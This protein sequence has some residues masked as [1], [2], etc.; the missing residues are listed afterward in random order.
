[1]SVV[2]QTLRRAAR[3]VASHTVNLVYATQLPPSV[4]TPIR[5]RVDLDFRANDPEALRL[6]LSGD[7]DY[8]I[9][10]HV[11][12]R[13]RIALDEGE[14]CMSAWSGPALAWYAMAQ[15][16]HHRVGARR[17]P[18]GQACSYVYL[19]YTHPQWRG[20]GVCSAGLYHLLAWLT[21]RGCRKALLDVTPE[22][23]ASRRVI[24][25]N[26]MRLVSRFDVYRVLGMRWATYPPSLPRELGS[27]GADATRRRA[28]AT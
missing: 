5:A 26:G 25:R 19:G 16:D 3:R 2:L 22:N 11:A 4:S 27:V 9:E 10:P 1:M 6:M 21:Q 8:G 7:P 24:E 17:I 13:L 15:F 18:L 20:Q 14:V 28:G 12:A 23:T